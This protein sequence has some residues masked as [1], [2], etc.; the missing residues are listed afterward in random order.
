M[1]ASKCCIVINAEVDF[2]WHGF[3]RNTKLIY[4]MGFN[5]WADIILIKNH[6]ITQFGYPNWA[7]HSRKIIFSAKQNTCVVLSHFTIAKQ[8]CL[9]DVYLTQI[10]FNASSSWNKWCFNL[11]NDKSLIKNDEKLGFPTASQ[12]RVF[13][14]FLSVACCKW[15]CQPR[16]ANCDQH[17]LICS[18]FQVIVINGK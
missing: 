13:V 15:T 14:G 8:L 18:S 10:I 17:Q 16:T 4:L 6:M 3:M 1:P 5:W 11:C 2:C 9:P 12:K 7:V